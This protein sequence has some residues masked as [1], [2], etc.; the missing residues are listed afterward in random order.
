L[1]NEEAAEVIGVSTATVERDW[2]MAKAWL[3]RELSRG[4]SRALVDE[5]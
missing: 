4:D 1:T 5:R 2:R 3:H